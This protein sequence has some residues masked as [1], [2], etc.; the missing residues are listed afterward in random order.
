MIQIDKLSPRVSHKKWRDLK[1][2]AAHEDSLHVDSRCV[3]SGS[4]LSR[5]DCVMVTFIPSEWW[6]ILGFGSCL[7]TVVMMLSTWFA[8]ENQCLFCLYICTK[9]KFQHAVW[10][11]YVFCWSWFSLF[12]ICM[13]WTFKLHTLPETNSLPQIGHLEM[14]FH[15]PP[16]HFQGRFVRFMEGIY[17]YRTQIGPNFARFDQL[18]GR[19]TPKK[20]FRWVLFLHIYIYIILCI[21]KHV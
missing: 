17:T 5:C 6:C 15:L 4:A 10:C 1:T 13:S 19:S 18:N 14:G 20:H 3:T 7:M 2:P 8:N 9:C 16:I 12:S 21:C 11:C